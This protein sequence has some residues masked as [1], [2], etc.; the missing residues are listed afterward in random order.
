MITV[1]ARLDRAFAFDAPVEA[2]YALLSDVPR[3]ARLFPRVERVDAEP[4]A[5]GAEAW[6]WTMEALGPPG[7][8]VQTVYACRY[9]FDP[10][11]HAVAWAPMPELGN[12]RFSGGVD[13]DPDG[14]GSRGR[15][16]L[17]A[18]LDLPAPRFAAGLVRPA[19]RLEFERMTGV[20]L[21]RVAE[22]LRG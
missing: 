8:A 9:A 10:A 15:L 13:L 5:D 20:F 2:A 21:S 22:A 7:Y 1:D 11:A 19:V 17:E 6:R 18:S 4:T 12:A 3:W 16:R 14:A